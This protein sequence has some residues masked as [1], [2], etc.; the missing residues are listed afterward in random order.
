MFS[1]VNAIRRCFQQL[2]GFLGSSLFPCLGACF[3]Q[4]SGTYGSKMAAGSITEFYRTSTLSW[5]AWGAE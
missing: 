1:S 4:R 3:R 2:P 5:H